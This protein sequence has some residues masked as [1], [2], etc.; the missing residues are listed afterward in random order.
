MRRFKFQSAGRIIG[1]LK[2]ISIVH[3]SHSRSFQSAGRIIGWLKIRH[4]AVWRIILQVS[5]RRADYWLVEDVGLYGQ[6]GCGKEFQSAGRIIGWLK[7]GGGIS[8]FVAGI[9][10]IRR[11][12]YW[13]VEVRA[14]VYGG[15]CEAV[16]IRRA[17]YWLVEDATIRRCADCGDVSIRRADYWLVEVLTLLVLPHHEVIGFNPPGG[18]L[19]G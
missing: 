1:W 5:I 13:L 11:A 4:L 8:F 2:H 6:T 18:L 9:V 17:D 16:S 10:S 15:R 12:D 19:V 14:S 3:V 7:L